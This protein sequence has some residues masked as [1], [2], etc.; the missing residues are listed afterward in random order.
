MCTPV[1]VKLPDFLLE[2][3]N[4]KQMYLEIENQGMFALEMEEKC[5]TIT[6]DTQIVEEYDTEL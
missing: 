4:L 6:L 5:D 3:E 2:K 1:F